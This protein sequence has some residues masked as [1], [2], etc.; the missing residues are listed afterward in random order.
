MNWLAHLVLSE[1]SPAFKVGNVLADILPIGELRVLP[2]AYQ[3]GIA[4]HRAIDAFTDKH[5]IF[6]QSIGR[7][8]SRYRR[9]GGVIMDVFY[10]HFL[11]ANWHT[12][13][14]EP[15][16]AFVAQFHEDVESCRR[17]IP[18]GAYTILLRMDSGRWLTANHSVEGVRT[19]LERISRR[20]RKPF[21]LAGAAGD[22][23]VHRDSLDADF[24]AFF[25]QIR[26][27]FQE[28]PTVQ[29]SSLAGPDQPN[30]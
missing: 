22:L 24:G 4:R 20:L 10:D 3:A 28:G 1:N 17:E 14:E 21:D 7:L 23:A 15:V 11:T 12:W 5:P 2:P 30:P 9:Y 6:K 25:P 19:T 27:H 18:A 13:T 26:S 16:E 29:T 8:D